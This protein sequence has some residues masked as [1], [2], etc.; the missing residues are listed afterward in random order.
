MLKAKTIFKQFINTHPIH[1]TFD[2]AFKISESDL[3]MKACK[4]ILEGSDNGVWHSNTGFLDVFY[5]LVF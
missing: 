1:I 2:E 4:E 5:C 3:N